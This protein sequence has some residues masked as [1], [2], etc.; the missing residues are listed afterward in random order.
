MK[1][2]FILIILTALLSAASSTDAQNTPKIIGKP[3]F[4]PKSDMMTPEA[5]WSF[6]RIGEVIVSPDKS[7]IAFGVKYFD[8][9]DNKGNTEIYTMTADGKN[10]KQITSTPKSEANI[11]WRPDGKKIGFL[12]ID[13]KGVMQI[14]EMNPDGT[15]RKQISTDADG[16]T[17]FSYSP[18]G[19]KIAFSKELTSL[20]KTVQDKYPDLPKANGKIFDDLMISHWDSWTESF[21]HLFLADFDGAKLSNNMDLNQDGL[22]DAPN[23][24][25]GGM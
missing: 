3:D 10:L 14:W 9:K 12:Y 23:K 11:V 4:K 1:H 22:Y 15:D 7:T 25:F 21:S 20:V 8:I 13:D 24:P 6:G 2:L 18:D 5:L 16:I 17:G 19:K